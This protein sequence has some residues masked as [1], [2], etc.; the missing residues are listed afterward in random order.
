M[1]TD[2]LKALEEVERVIAQLEDTSLEE[3]EAEKAYNKAMHLLDE[4]EKFLAE[5]EL[6]LEEVKIE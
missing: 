6:K 3:G 2:I 4:A 1:A 5:N